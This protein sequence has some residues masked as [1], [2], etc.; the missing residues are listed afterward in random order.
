MFGLAPLPRFMYSAR[1]APAVRRYW[2]QP[3]LGT[4]PGSGTER[5]RPS[6]QGTGTLGPLPQCSLAPEPVPGPLRPPDKVHVLSSSL[7]FTL[8]SV[9]H[10]PHLHDGLICDRSPHPS[11][12]GRDWL[13][14]APLLPTVTVLILIYLGPTS[15]RRPVRYIC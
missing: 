12:P 13:K 10:Q 15:R 11:A 8:R 4:G 3:V 6:H 2:E 5:P 1:R 14:A 9:L 7:F